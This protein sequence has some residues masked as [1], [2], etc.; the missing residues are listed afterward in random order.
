VTYNKKETEMI[1]VWVCRYQSSMV[2]PGS[3]CE[4]LFWYKH[5]EGVPDL[6]AEVN[7]LRIHREASHIRGIRIGLA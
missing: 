2:F 7:Y 1:S 5:S 3:L 4:I 6:F